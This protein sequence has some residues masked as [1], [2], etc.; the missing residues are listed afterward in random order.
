MLTK[1]K[2]YDKAGAYAIQEWIGVVGIKSVNGDFYNVM[3]LPGKPRYKGAGKF[4]TMK[5]FREMYLVKRHFIL[6]LEHVL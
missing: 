4:L 2:P 1:Y 3:G 6:N 5:L